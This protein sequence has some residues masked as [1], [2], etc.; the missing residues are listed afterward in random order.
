MKTSHVIVKESQSI[1]FLVPRQMNHPQWNSS[2]FPRSVLIAEI[3]L[4]WKLGNNQSI[5]IAG[6]LTTG[7]TYTTGNYKVTF[8]EVL[9]GGAVRRCYWKW[10]RTHAQPEMTSPQVT[11]SGPDRKSR[12]WSRAHAQ[13]VPRFFLIIV[14]VQNVGR[15]P[16]GA[17]MHFSI[18]LF[19]SLHMFNK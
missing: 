1:L 7:T 14:V 19:F 2:Q 10:S 4:H 3:L 12:K 8:E 6:K 15:V 5:S 16:S 11:G 9:C 18:Y 13:I 17:R